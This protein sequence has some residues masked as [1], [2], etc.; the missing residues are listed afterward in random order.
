MVASWIGTFLN[1]E[2]AYIEPLKPVFLM[3][4]FAS[5]VGSVSGIIYFFIAREAWPAITLFVVSVIGVASNVYGFH[6]AMN[7]L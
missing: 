7:R 5:W 3:L 1:P 4:F 2:L 6:W